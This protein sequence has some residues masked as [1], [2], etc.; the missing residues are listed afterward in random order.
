VLVLFEPDENRQFRA[1]LANPEADIS[2]SVDKELI[3]TI[4]QTLD[5]LLGGN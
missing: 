5:S 2:K 1:V 3:E 4:A